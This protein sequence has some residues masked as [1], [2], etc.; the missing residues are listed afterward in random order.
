MELLKK[1]I[2]EIRTKKYHLSI[3]SNDPNEP[4]KNINFSKKSL[5][6]YSA[7]F[8]VLIIILMVSLFYIIPLGNM[9]KKAPDIAK[10]KEIELK[11][12][13]IS[14]EVLI[15]QEYNN[16]LKFALGDTSVGHAANY[17]TL[18]SLLNSLGPVE[19]KNSPNSKAEL[20][21]SDDNS[22]DIPFS[23]PVS[24]VVVSQEFDDE[25]NHLGVDFAGKTGDPV[26]ATADGVVVFSNYTVDYG[27]TMILVHGNKFLTKYK[28]NLSNLKSVGNYVHRGEMIAMLGNTGRLSTSPHLH[29]EIWKNGVAKNPFKYLITRN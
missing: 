5:I 27:N 12:K 2:T 11:V 16:Q 24:N 1:Y 29:F 13:K 17:R 8:V 7:L 20:T 18:D 19:T 26:Y 10:L 14:S 9:T 3:F 28:H 15:L 21:L 4:T 23:L 6:F 25:E 22:L